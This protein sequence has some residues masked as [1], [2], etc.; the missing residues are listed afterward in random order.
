MITIIFWAGRVAEAYSGQVRRVKGTLVNYIQ[1]VRQ[2]RT[3]GVYGGKIKQA[4]DDPA[5]SAAA[6]LLWLIAS[7]ENEEVNQA[8]SADEEQSI[9]QSVVS[10]I[11]VLAAGQLLYKRFPKDAASLLYLWS[12]YGSRDET[13]R[14][15]TGS[16]Q[17]GAGNVIE[18][19]K[20]Y[21]PA[22]EG[23]KR[24]KCDLD[25]VCE[26]HLAPCL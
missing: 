20:C 4:E 12:H 22:S 6:C 25:V 24:G 5:I 23:L 9:E 8:L 16:F 1:K 26:Y 2:T 14:Y 18:F 10:R 7:E 13:N 3:A 21:L 19:L 17:S 11:R 15:L